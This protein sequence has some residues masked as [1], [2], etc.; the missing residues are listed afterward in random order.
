MGRPMVGIV[1]TILCSVALAYWG[2]RSGIAYEKGK[3]DL[4]ISMSR[5]NGFSWAMHEAK[6]NKQY[7]AANQSRLKQ[8]MKMTGGQTFVLGGY[9]M[10]IEAM[11]H[12]IEDLGGAS[13][14]T[15]AS[16]KNFV[17][18]YQNLQ[19]TNDVIDDFDRIFVHASRSGNAKYTEAPLKET[20]DGS[21][22]DVDFIIDVAERECRRHQRLVKS[23]P[24][25]YVPRA[26]Q[27]A[28]LRITDTGE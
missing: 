19:R 15:E 13:F 2:L 17:V 5:L 7:A 9:R 12:I 10:R 27:E 21:A 14:D 20:F 3:A 16:F 23:V 22:K 26:Q 1:I 28:V 18:L 6:T 4:E 11:K 25:D 8:A 24:E